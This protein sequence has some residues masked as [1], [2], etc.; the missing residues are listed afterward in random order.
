[1]HDFEII[2]VGAGPSGCATALELAKLDP[3]I[4]SRVLLLDR[5]VFPRVKLCAGGMIK[6]AD[7]ILGQLGLRIDLPSHPVHIS[8]FVLPTGCLTVRHPDHFRV[9]RRD[10]FDDL[11]FQT[12]RRRGVVTRDGESV[13]NITRTSQDIVIR[14]SK[15]EYR[16]KIV[17]GADGANSTVRRLVGLPR[18]DR[19]MIAIETFAS[20]GET[21]IPDFS[22]NMAIFD[23]SVTSRGVP[24]Y[25]WIFPTVSEEPPV[26]S[27]GIM[28]APFRKDE[29][30]HL[31]DSFAEWLGEHGIDA[32][33]F[34]Q[35]SH[36]LL[37]YEPRAPCS[38]DRVLLTGDAAGVDPLFGEG[39]T[40][41]LALGMIAA[42]SANNAIRS[43]DFS[44]STY[45]K[46]IRSS[47]IGRTMRRRRFLAR[48]LYAKPRFGRRYL[49]YSTLLKWIAFLRPETSVGKIT[50]ETSQ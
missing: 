48:R 6:D 49:Q 11:L 21:D 36:P 40:S 39:I 31:R 50:W 28:A 37:R 9:I 42:Q 15:N 32:N 4:T 41:A 45:D 33:R 7:V 8:K 10:Q 22:R 26:V 29:T 46:R 5:A 38:L 13:D 2:I 30:F 24:G 14:T 25:C 44:F 1:M 18:H 19:L 20:L 16:T 43:N 47:A 12:A 35:K 23:L 34:E 17:I 3:D 27:L